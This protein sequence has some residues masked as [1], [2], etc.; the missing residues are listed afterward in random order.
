MVR[1]TH[2]I[3]RNGRAYFR[4]RLPPELRAISKP[5]HWPTELDELVSEANREKLKHELSRALGTRDEREAKRRA[6]VEV[7][8]VE[9]MIQQ[10]HEFLVNGSK[11]NLSVADIR[12]MAERYGAGL[13]VS[14]M[15]LRKAGIGLRLPT[16]GQS[17]A[18]KRRP[19]APTKIMDRS[20]P[21]LTTD[22]LG[23][24]QF[25]V[26]KL[27]PEINDALARQRPTLQDLV[28]EDYLT[29]RF[30]MPFDDFTTSSVPVTSDDYA[31]YRRRSIAFIE[32]RNRRIG[33]YSSEVGLSDVTLMKVLR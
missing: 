24:L 3:W 9:S 31:E 16:P 8:R 1:M 19:S 26:A 27:K 33:Q 12:L 21:G 15:D 13:I 23:L 25:A 32:G 5:K 7:A 14:D 6:A 10:A 17:L 28:T 29:I 18:I 2:L 22:D 11:K 20:E 30:F 4:Y